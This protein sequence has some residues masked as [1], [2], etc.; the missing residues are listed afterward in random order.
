MA[1]LPIA[2]P[3]RV[4]SRH[5]GLIAAFTTL[6]VLPVLASAL[7][8]WLVAADQYA[9][10]M[11]FSVR[12]EEVSSA[13]EILGG[14][15]ELSGSGSSDTDILNEYIRSQELVA[16]IDDRLDLRAIYARPD[17]DPIFAFDPGRPIEDLVAYWGRMVRIS[18]DGSSKLIEVRVHAFAPQDAQAIARAIFDESTVMINA[19]SAIAREDTTRYAREE[20]D[21][22]VERLKV[23]RE[24]VTRFR[25]RTQIVDP[26][27]DI[28]GQMG[29]LNTLQA[30][31]AEALIEQ[32]LLADTA[33][34][35]DPRVTQVNRRIAVIE[36]RIA[37]E[38]RKFGAG[39]ARED[40]Q[41]YATLISE[42]ERLSVDREF[43][44]QAYV[45]AMSAYDGALA[46]ARRQSRYL[47]AYIQPTLAQS[48][49]YPQRLLLTG[50]VAMF[51]VMGW[52]VLALIYYSLR[53]RR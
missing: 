48:A 49:Q 30:Q 44:Q 50:L 45:V 10:R 43:A 31:L 37:E 40:G 19:L 29:L 53:D 52:G 3:A 17:F 26:T 15:T 14:I 11:G 27:A 21:T 7:Y 39:G 33:Q 38:R 8:L 16:R 18:Y 4:R 5:W 24:A 34:P 1:G 25:S 6:V 23:A 41:D 28:Q 12:T 32:D 46:E 2:G 51:A 9:S 20:L 13:F 42:Y 36:D 22:A 35:G 47:A